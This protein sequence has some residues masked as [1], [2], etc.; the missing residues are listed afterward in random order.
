MAEQRVLL[1]GGVFYY[2]YR[3]NKKSGE[4]DEVEVKTEA[5]TSQVQEPYSVELITRV[6]HSSYD[7]DYSENEYEG[8]EDL[9]KINDT[10][11]F[12]YFDVSNN[13]TRRIVDISWGQPT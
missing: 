3:K 8:D 12:D 10:L 5:E 1:I 11:E 4:Q 13:K 9:I 7:S 6:I 2:F